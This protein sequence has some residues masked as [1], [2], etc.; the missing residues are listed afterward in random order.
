LRESKEF[1]TKGTGGTN[2]GEMMEYKGCGCGYHHTCYDHSD[3]KARMW[4]ILKKAKMELLKEKIKKNLEAA[5]GK[6]MDEIAKILVDAKVDLK[7]RKHEMY[8]V[9][10]E[11]MEKIWELFG[12]DGEK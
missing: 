3:P 12:G 11:M 10:E 2:M 7:K 4:Y 9:K 5:E 6:K 1:P 8:K